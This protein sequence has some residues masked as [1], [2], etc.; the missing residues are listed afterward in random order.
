LTTPQK[1]HAEHPLPVLCRA[2]DAAARLSPGVV[3]QDI[4]AAEALADGG[5]Q[6]PR[7]IRSAGVCR[8]GH[9]IGGAA[10]RGGERL[11]GAGEADAGRAAGDDGDGVGGNGRVAARPPRRSATR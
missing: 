5:L 11:S 10:R 9:D 4:R 7:L 6:P 1:V 2:E 3:H 8:H